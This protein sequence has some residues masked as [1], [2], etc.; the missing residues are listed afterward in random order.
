MNPDETNINIMDEKVPVSHELIAI[1]RLN[2]LPDNPR[3]YAAIREISDFDD[4][5][6]DEQQPLMYERLL[7]EPSVKN[8][9]REIERDGGLQEPVIVRYDKLQVIEGN[10]RLAVYRYLKGKNPDKEKW[11]EIPCLVVKTLSEEQQTRLLAQFHLHGKTEWTPYAKALFSFRWVK[12]QKKKIATLSKISGF[13]VAEIKKHVQII[14]LMMEN[15]DDK[16]SRFSYYDVLIR[17]RAISTAFAG[18][19]ELK[20]TLFKQIK[21]EEFTAQ[22]MR[23]RL[24]TVIKK[25]R[26]LRKYIKDDVTLN[27]A[28]QRAEVSGAEQKLKKI[29]D[30]LDD[31]EKKDIIS[32]EHHEVKAIQQV[33][34]QIKQN[35]GRVDEIVKNALAGGPN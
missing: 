31:I 26:I 34:R 35:I 19:S 10:S 21:S 27:N 5:T 3:V 13:T 7:Q 24:P 15:K 20:R 28:Y 25:P 8:L 22:E 12:E 14:E 2:F 23:D 6:S 4:L 32:L 18:D 11:S 16:L 9:I 29:R 1:E 33:V 17:N 30:R